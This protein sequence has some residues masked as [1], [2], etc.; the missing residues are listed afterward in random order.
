MMPD[1]GVKVVHAGRFEGERA[2]SV[3]APRGASR[4]RL[5]LSRDN[6]PDEAEVSVIATRADGTVIGGWTTKGGEVV[7]FRT[8]LVAADSWGEI[9]SPQP[10]PVDM[11]IT[12]TVAVTTAIESTL[13]FEAS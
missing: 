7:N 8:G 10:L 6:W 1:P 13:S 3:T 2:F 11:P 4:F 12:V 9:V 5:T